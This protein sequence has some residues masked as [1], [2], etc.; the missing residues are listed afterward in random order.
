MKQRETTKSRS[1]FTLSETKGL[2]RALI[3]EGA[4]EIPFGGLRTGF[5]LRLRTTFPD[6]SHD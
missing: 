2:P 6:C 5:A 3:D 1:T 4:K